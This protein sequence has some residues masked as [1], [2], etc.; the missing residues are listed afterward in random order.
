MNY[1][2]S[3]TYFILKIYFSI[4]LFN[5]NKHWTGPQ[6][7]RTVGGSGV[8]VSKTQRTVNWTAG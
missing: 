4:H 2:N 3:S 6:N 5:L 8:K 7:L 1:T